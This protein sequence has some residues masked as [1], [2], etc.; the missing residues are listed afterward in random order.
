MSLSY[1]IT[2][3]GGLLAAVGLL[4]VL[5][6][7]AMP[8]GA[9]RLRVF[10]VGAVALTLAGLVELAGSLAGVGGSDSLVIGMMLRVFGTGVSAG[11]ARDN[12]PPA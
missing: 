5:G 6:G 10:R 8:A 12:T 4:G 7:A 2:L 1:L 11:P 9:G 3:L